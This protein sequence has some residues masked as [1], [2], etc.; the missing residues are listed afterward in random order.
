MKRMDVLSLTNATHR[1]PDTEP[2]SMHTFPGLGGNAVLFAYPSGMQFSS[3]PPYFSFSG[4]L[5]ACL[6]LKEEP[7]Q[8]F[9][10]ALIFVLLVLQPEC[11]S[12]GLVRGS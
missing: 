3:L 9:L 7:L 11:S 6:P 5:D 2:G 10:P 4:D 12:H 8:C 1:G